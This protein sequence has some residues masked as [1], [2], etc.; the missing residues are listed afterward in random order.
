MIN[1]L[2]LLLKDPSFKSQVKHSIKTFPANEKI[3]KQGQLHV[4]IYVILTGK[5]RIIVNNDMENFH[6][7]VADLEPGHVFGELELYEDLPADADVKT[8]MECKVIEIDI[9]SFRKF[10]EKNPKKGYDILLLM[11]KMHVDR[12]RHADK[13]IIHLYTWGLKMHHYDEALK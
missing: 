1:S 11:F 8:M 4:N 5:M 10:L 2:Q 12:I 3:I 9:K 7:G 6:P 13:A